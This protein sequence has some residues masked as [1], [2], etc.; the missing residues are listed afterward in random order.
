LGLR[1]LTLDQPPLHKDG[2]FA[3]GM[4]RIPIV[5]EVNTLE[6]KS[7]LVIKPD[8]LHFF[9]LGLE[10]QNPDARGESSGRDVFH[11][12]FAEA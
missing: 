3:V 11:Q 5:R 10:H 9:V 8:G 12:L 2:Y 4:V 6:A 7:G 1:R